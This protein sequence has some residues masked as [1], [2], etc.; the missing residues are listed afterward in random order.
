MSLPNALAGRRLWLLGVASLAAL[1]ALAVAALGP[2]QQRASADGHELPPNLA[3]N[4]QLIEDSDNIVPAGSELTVRA[5]ISHSGSPV[6]NTAAIEAPASAKAAGFGSSEGVLRVSGSFEWESESSTGSRLNLANAQ[7]V[8]QAN[9]GIDEASDVIVGIDDTSSATPKA[10]LP[11]TARGRFQAAAWDGRTMIARVL[12]SSAVL[13]SVQIYEYSATDN[14][15]SYRA[16]L[17]DA[18]TTNTGP[19]NN[20]NWHERFAVGRDDQISPNLSPVAVWHED[21]NTAW[22]F[23]G[24]E[25]HN[26]HTSNGQLTGAVFVYKI[27]YSA[28]SAAV[29]LEATL[30]P[31]DRS[32][33][34][35]TTPEASNLKDASPNARA[36][37]GSSLALS[38]DGSTLVVAARQMNHIGAL[39]VYTRPSGANED[40]GDIT[41]AA[42]VKVTPVVVPAW[43]SGPSNRPFT[44][45]AAG[46]CNAY[47]RAVTAHEQREGASGE[48]DRPLLGI[49]KIG[50][51]AD[52]SVIAVGAPGKQYADDTAA[53][54]FSSGVDNGQVFIYEAPAGGWTSVADVTG[55]AIAARGAI[56][57]HNAFDPATHY[58]PG[59]A[60]RITAATATLRPTGSWTTT[61]T[62]AENFGVSVDV[63]ADGSTIAV[64]SG[65]SSTATPSGINAI[66]RNANAYIFERSGSS[67]SGDITS[68]TAKYTLHAT[69]RQWAPYG[70]ELNPAGDTLIFGQHAYVGVA[71]RA[72]VI[73]KGDGWS[74]AT[75]PEAAI[76]ASDTMWQLTQPAFDGSTFGTNF[77]VPL[78]NLDGDRLLI[79]A[80][81]DQGGGNHPGS[82]W[83]W[84]VTGAPVCTSRTLDDLT[85]TTCPIAIPDM[86][87]V[88]IPNGSPDGAFTISGSVKLTRGSDDSTI[89]D[90]LEVT[91]GKVDEVASVSI[92]VAPDL[93]DP[94]TS[95]DDTTYPTVLR[96]SGAKTR[97]QLKI[98]NSG[99]K[100]TA[101]G[102]LASVLVTSTG[103]RL[104]LVSAADAPN[105]A[106]STS[107]ADLSCQITTSSINAG[108]AANILLQLEHNNRPTTARI[109][110]QVLSSS[111]TSLRAE[112]LEITLAGPAET[113]SV[114]APIVGVLNVDQVGSDDDGNDVDTATGATQ[115]ELLLAVS[116]M[117]AGGNTVAVPRATSGRVTVSDPDGNRVR[118]G[119]TATFPARKN[120]GENITTGCTTT[121]TDGSG[122]TCPGAAAGD[123]RRDATS[124]D[125]PAIVTSAG[126]FQVKIDVDAAASSPLK[127]GEYTVEVTAGGKSGT[128]KFNVSGGPAATG[129]DLMGPEGRQAVGTQFTV[130]ATINDSEG[131]PVPD[132]TSVTWVAP[133]TTSGAGRAT[134]V[135]STNEVNRTKDGKASNTYL[136]VGAGSVVIRATAGAGADAV[137]VQ[138]GG[139]APTAEPANPAD[140]L[141]S[142]NPDAYTT[143]RGEGRTSAADLLAGL[144]NISSVLLW[145]NGEWLRYGVVDGVE[146]PGSRDFTV[147]PGQV[148]WLS[149]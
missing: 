73:K 52:G 30:E 117:D 125:N 33:A 96:A 78:Y 100:A 43:G 34:T 3:F 127:G 113:I 115:D 145:L 83:N 42:G 35:P 110:V 132:G 146:I 54:A 36:D 77:G 116:A 137:S 21:D 90:T 149:R 142:R 122:G 16:Q 64:S 79:S 56:P 141:S 129:F 88:V 144:D 26:H 32:G 133:R 19:G 13:P 72:V 50:I 27:A 2:L 87:K 147:N 44:P 94:T 112:P 15:F 51:S 131:N 9:A 14:S 17:Q 136:V 135:V 140:A 28:T 20:A 53:T 80:P 49:G 48:D 57:T 91:V 95:N 1:L 11:N 123:P 46:T 55:T 139:A 97:L 81:G 59:P 124:A 138:L 148:L 71:G 89:R 62:E 8:A 74:S 98:L 128:A 103:G 18:P 104:S 134:L 82:V 106:T 114:A 29:T 92:G 47:C 107:C 24:S 5:T 60:K 67:W 61:A 118:S 25:G 85:T 45:G 22:L 40:W 38:A 41:Y 58:S 31:V 76:T 93:K 75:I 86:G 37:Y 68:P 109:S 84:H 119:I 102:N 101:A 4:L 108:N 99:G 10:A 126:L 130:E 63:S 12:A 120:P 143:W 7:F 70:F 6:T 105:N 39:Y 111:G 23:I 66:N 65:F 121:S 69:N